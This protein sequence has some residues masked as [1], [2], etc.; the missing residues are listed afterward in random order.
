MVHDIVACVAL[1]FG[2]VSQT[3]PGVEE[4]LTRARMAL[5][6]KDF[7]TA[8]ACC[9][10]AIQSDR[11]NTIAYLLRG[12]IFLSTNQTDKALED[13]SAAV[14]LNP[15]DPKPLVHTVFLRSS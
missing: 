9:D 13:F 2:L 12:T 1:A 8:L 10:A 6:K 5:D 14:H 4:N 11:N 3:T 7:A 15:G